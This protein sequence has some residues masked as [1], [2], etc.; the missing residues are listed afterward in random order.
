MMIADTWSVATGNIAIGQIPGYRTMGIGDR[1]IIE[2]TTENGA[3]AL[4][5]PDV[6]GHGLCLRSTLAG[7]LCQFHHQ[8]LG[9]FFCRINLKFSH[10]QDLKLPAVV[11]A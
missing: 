3:H 1:S 4:M 7:C 10:Y 8:E 6:P 11:Q 2:I 5:L 9:G